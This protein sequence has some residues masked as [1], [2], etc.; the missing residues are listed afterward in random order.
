[1]LEVGNGGMT[2][3]EYRSHFSMWSVMAAPLLIGSDLRKASPA[4]F[5][6][7][8]NKEVIAVDQDPWASRAPCS[9]PRA[10]A[11]SSPRR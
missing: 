11:G 4:T 8:D 7:L 2:D 9:P 6:I 10:D 5:D 3:T 1:M